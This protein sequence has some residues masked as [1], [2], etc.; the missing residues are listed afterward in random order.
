MINKRIVWAGLAAGVLCHFLQGSGAYFIFDRFYFE[1][2]DIV[3]DPGLI[4]GIYYLLINMVLGV[5][6][7]HLAYYFHGVWEDTSWKI[8]LR[9][10]LILW[11]GSSPIWIA[12][13]QILLKLSNWLLLEII[14]DLIVF[15]LVGILAGFLVGIIIRREAKE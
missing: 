1:N 7:A 9:A 12:K 15:G 11:A 6:I 8:G 2:P 13:R 5:V 10:G 3:R 14:F 4:V